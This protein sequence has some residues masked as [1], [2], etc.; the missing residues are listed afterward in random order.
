MLTPLTVPPGVVRASTPAQSRG[1]WWDANLVRWRSG[2]LEPVGGWERILG[3]PMPSI[4]RALHWWADLTGIRRLAVGAD[5]GLYT[6]EGSE[7]T[8]RTP[9]LF[10]PP[11]T[12]AFGQ[13]GFGIGNYGAGAF[14]APRPAPDVR[15]FGRPPNWSIDNFGQNLLFLCSTDGKL[16]ELVPVAGALPALGTAVADAPES[17]RAMVV[18]EERHVMLLGSG[19]IPNRVAWCSREDYEDWDFASTTNTAGFFDLPIGG[20]IIAGTRVRGG[21]LLWTENEAWLARYVGQ[22]FIYSFERVGEACGLYGP[23]TYAAAP[24]FTLWMGREGFFTYDGG[25]VRPLQSDVAD[26]VFSGIDRLYGPGRAFSVSNGLFPEVWWHYPSQG[27]AEPDRYVCFSTAEGW[28]S[29]GAMDRAAG[30]GA[31]VYPYPVLAGGDGFLYQHELGWLDAGR[32][33]V[34]R[35]YAETGALEI[36]RGGAI[37]GDV[38]GAHMDSGAGFDATQVRAYARFTREGPEYV[39]GPYRAEPDGLMPVR[40]SA[41]EFR[42]R[43]EAR[44]DTD[45]AIGEMRLDIE[46]GGER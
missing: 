21:V 24:G 34:G 16:H 25:A 28:W 30:V 14:G 10:V 22:P 4:P 27:S 37:V 39:S 6:I 15:V 43:I 1:R 2:M 20:Y 46:T 36:A 44:K 3:A 31:G 33:R 18:T 41:R 29:I 35:V 26:F 12:A 17:N 38:L 9:L 11:S 45:W 7:V 5:D 42:L 13:G 32:T 19:G 8:D 40:F 23:R